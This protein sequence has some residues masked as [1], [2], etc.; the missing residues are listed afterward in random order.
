MKFENNDNWL[1]IL[2]K[3]NFGCEILFS[4]RCEE[5]VKNKKCW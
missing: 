3:V 2:E 4:P 1:D 5:F